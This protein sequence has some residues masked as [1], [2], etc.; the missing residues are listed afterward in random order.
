MP[1]V[2]LKRFNNMIRL[3][4]SG[5][6]GAQSDFKFKRFG[7]AR[8]KISPFLRRV[9]SV[10]TCIYTQ[11]DGELLTDGRRAVYEGSQQ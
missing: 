9:G 4:P 8:I 3:G 1:P 2:S 5:M 6:E 11:N 7:L 10:I